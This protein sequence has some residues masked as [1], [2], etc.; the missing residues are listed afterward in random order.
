MFGCN[1]LCR[2]FVFFILAPPKFTDVLPTVGANDI[3]ES[4]FTITL[5]HF[6]E[7]NGPIR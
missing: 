3:T 5:I 2:L 4:T 6:S 1:Y 7:I